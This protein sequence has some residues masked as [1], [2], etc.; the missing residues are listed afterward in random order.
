[1]ADDVVLPIP[2]LELPQH[3]FTVSTP[4]LAHLHDGARQALLKGI[5]ADR[6]FDVLFSFIHSLTV[7]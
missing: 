2:N 4:S 7:E 5:E 1:M 6:R 3:F